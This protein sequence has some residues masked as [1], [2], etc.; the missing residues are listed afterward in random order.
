MQVLREIIA[1]LAFVV[2]CV[3]LADLVSN[4]FNWT[5]LFI[6]VL[7]FVGAYIIWP[8]KKKGQR[9]DG[10]SFIDILEV[11]IELPVEI[12]LW[13]LKIIGRILGLTDRQGRS[14]G[15]NSGGDGGIDFDI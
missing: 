4:G 1:V 5:N 11:L 13:L 8:S 3:L 14:R 2:G 7:C 12:F 10:N 9:D 15:G 6:V